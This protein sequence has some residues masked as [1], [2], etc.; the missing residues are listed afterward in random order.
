[1][2]PVPLFDLKFLI[3]FAESGVG[4][5]NRRHWP[6]RTTSFWSAYAIFGASLMNRARISARSKVEWGRSTRSG[7]IHVKIAEQSV[8]IDRLSDR[9]ARIERRLDLPEA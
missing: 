3:E 8:R 9:V 6:R 4:T 1:M 5:S 7:T 2:I